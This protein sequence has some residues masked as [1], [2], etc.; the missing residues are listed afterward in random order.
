Y[1]FQI[2]GELIPLSA[3]IVS[4]ADVYDALRMRRS[5]KPGFT[6]EVAVEKI[7]E[8]RGTQFDPNLI[9]VFFTIAESFNEIYEKNKD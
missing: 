9:D 8:G 7:S 6:H 1:P 4:L 2:E 5:Y 3:R